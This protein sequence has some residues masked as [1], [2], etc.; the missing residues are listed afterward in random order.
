MAKFRIIVTL[1]SHDTIKKQAINGTTPLKEEL[2]VS[3]LNRLLQ[4]NLSC[5]KKEKVFKEVILPVTQVVSLHTCDKIEQLSQLQQSWI[6]NRD[7]YNS[8]QSNST[9]VYQAIVT[10]EQRLNLRMQQL[11]EIADMNESGDQK[12]PL[13]KKEV[14][15][16]I[17]EHCDAEN[18]RDEMDGVL[19]GA[20]KFW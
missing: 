13:V 1:I 16:E 2:T 20:L 7:Q 4:M 14:K 10:F 5:F 15:G 17:E 8:P 18:G 19:E 12:A 6:A 11:E 9:A 3:L